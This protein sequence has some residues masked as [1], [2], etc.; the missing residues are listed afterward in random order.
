MTEQR[1]SKIVKDAVYLSTCS[2]ENFKK[3]F[4]DILTGEATK[5]MVKE[6]LEEERKSDGLLL[7]YK[8]DREEYL[9]LLLENYDCIIRSLKS[10][11]GSLINREQEL[12]IMKF[13]A[14]YDVTK[15]YDAASLSR[16]ASLS[17]KLAEEYY[18]TDALVDKLEE[19]F[20]KLERLNED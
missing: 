16:I 8:E 7:R 15:S 5:K 10:T 17:R 2:Q 13:G 1:L 19:Q 12:A 11:I 4:D 6:F 20:A 14:S 9:K 18:Y 3:Y